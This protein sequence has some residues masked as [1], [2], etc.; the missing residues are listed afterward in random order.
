M[1]ATPPAIPP[2]PTRGARARASL[3]RP[4]GAWAVVALGVLA[5][6][7]PAW[8]LADPLG[9]AALF[10]DDFAYAAEARDAPTL[11]AHILTPRNTHVVP[12]FRL[13]TFLLVTMAG[14]LANLPAV[15]AAASYFALVAAEAAVGSLVARATRSVAAGLAAMAVLGIS[16]VIEPA[17]VW[18][19]AG[20]ALWAGTAVALTL[21]AAESWRERG[22]GRRLALVALGTVAAPAIWTGGLVAGPAAATLLWADG[23]RAPRRAALAIL[24]IAAVV[25][26]LLLGLARRQVAEVVAGPGRRVPAPARAV[27]A[28]RSTSLAI[29]EVLILRNLGVD[30]ALTPAQAALLAGLVAAAW[31]RSSRR[32]PASPP[33]AAGAVVVLFSYG[34]VYYFRGD[35]PYEDVRPVGWYHAIPQVGAILFAAGWWSRTRKR[36]RSSVT[37][38]I[39]LDRSPAPLTRRGGLAVLGLTLALVALHEERAGRLF[40]VGAPPMSAAEAK[41]YASPRLRRQRALAHAAAHRDRQAR[42]LARL[43]EVERVGRRLGLGRETI[44]RAFGRRLVPGLPDAQRESDAAGLL[45][46]PAGDPATIGVDEVRRALDGLIA[47][48]PPGPPPD[49]IP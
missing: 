36:T 9:H 3:S 19:S 13:W 10:G 39:D 17:V 49:P 21:L 25:A 44:R 41:R 47:E 2:G 14:R 4:A 22:G 30:A 15:F 23:R 18:Y 48:E 35:M 29:P 1:D 46:L 16:T 32:Q 31:W 20:Q 38:E 27:E 12:L 45:A 24:A 5:A 8:L 28:V 7:I 11:A 26:A 33:E 42:M 37:G 43:E 34:M 40:L 6:S